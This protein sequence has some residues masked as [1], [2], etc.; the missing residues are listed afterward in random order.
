VPGEGV[1]FSPDR[2]RWALYGGRQVILYD[3][4]GPRP[5]GKPLP[6]SEDYM[7]GAAF[8]PDGKILAVAY[9]RDLA[10]GVI[11]L[12]LVDRA[13]P[14]RALG[15]GG[16]G[17]GDGVILFDPANRS[18][19]GEP[20]LVPEGGVASLA[21]SPAGR[22]LAAGYGGHISIRDDPSEK[23]R[24]FESLAPGYY[25]SPDGGVLL[26]DVSGRPPLGEPIG[27]PERGRS[28]PA[29]SPDGKVVAVASP[30]TSPKPGVILYDAASSQPRGEPLAVPEGDIDHLA[31]SPDGET[32]I[33]GYSGRDRS[34][35]V[36]FFDV[37]SHLRVREPITSPKGDSVDLAFSPDGKT[38]AEFG[39]KS[40]VI[41]HD[42]ARRP[43]PREL[44]QIHKGGVSNVVFSPGG[45]TLAVGYSLYGGGGVV[46][47]DVASRRELGEPLRVP[48]M[49]PSIVAFSPDGRLLVAGYSGGAGRGGG[50][51]MFDIARR[52]SLADPLEVREGDIS[53]LKFSPDGKVL[54]LGFIEGFGIGGGGVVLKDVAGWQRFGVPLR[55]H[56]SDFV[57]VGAFSPDGKSLIATHD[58][59]RIRFDLDPESWQRRACLIANRNPSR[60]E[61][62][63]LIAPGLPYRR[64]CPDLPEPD[65]RRSPEPRR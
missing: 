9:R 28:D 7:T 5:L 25:G 11:L 50:L 47:F 10:G 1:A 8:S 48:S 57:V 35:G 21:F 44:L 6:V 53:S 18:R 41:L 60:D 39:G 33:V 49:G 40:G 19:L 59:G 13:Q 3:A 24:K 30:R 61:W 27:V 37:A 51:M 23:A 26:F 55:F 22:T 15:Y 43:R 34:R 32:L 42:L 64:L 31:F 20:L 56:Q 29:S 52:R 65:D 38:I 2:R 17:T 46:L 36:I 12:D 62:D 16:S 58:G 63:R 14:G 45:R 4:E 54:A